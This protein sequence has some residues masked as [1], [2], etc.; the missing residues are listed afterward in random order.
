[1]SKR[2]EEST[3]DASSETKAE[4]QRGRKAGAI[5]FP[6]NSL[7]QA[8][9]IPTAIWNSNAGNPFAIGDLADKVGLSPTSSGFKELIR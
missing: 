1:M 3:Q 2:D 7:L 9:R 8:L 4:G 5:Y 6:R